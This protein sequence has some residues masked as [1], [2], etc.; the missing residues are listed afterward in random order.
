MAFNFKLFFRLTYYAFFKSKGT[1]GRLTGKRLRALALWYLVFPFYNLITWIC[2][3]LDDILFPQYR[4][5][6]VKDPT[7]IIGNFRSGST[8]L[9]RLLA[10][11][12]EIFTSMKTWEI[13]VAPSLVQ[14]KFLFWGIG[15]DRKVLKGAILKFVHRFDERWL[16]PVPIHSIGLFEAEEDEG[17]L[18]YNW[19]SSFLMFIY[20]FPDSLPPYWYFDTQVSERDQRLS[21]RF[22]RGIVQR[23]VY[24]HGGKRYL[25]KNPIS[26]VKIKALRE[27]FPDAKFIYLVRNPVDMLASKTSFFSFAW[28][29]FNQ[30]MER[31]PFKDVLLDFTRHCYTYPLRRL[32]ELPTSEYMILD[33]DDL[34]AE[35]ESSTK[36][37]YNHFGIPMSGRFSSILDE[38]VEQ[39]ASYISKHH[40]SLAEMGYTPEQVYNLY[41]D[42]FERFNFELD[43]KAMVAQVSKH[44]AVID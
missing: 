38:A 27:Y 14:R 25:A 19:T 22:Y 28:H 11:D 15:I 16:K 31:Y 8:L 10:Q 44:E 35:L 23:H 32:S 40:Y 42:V 9:Q 17:V 37:I 2:L 1:H 24:F 21:M 39:S 33:Y 36:K 18:L 12:E 26:C 13:Y 7:F 30:P 6:V 3:L 43:G 29:Y 20:P 4:N 34:V 41:K 5:Q